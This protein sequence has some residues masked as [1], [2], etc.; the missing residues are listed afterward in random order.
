MSTR[1]NTGS[2][3]TLLQGQTVN[4]IASSSLSVSVTGSWLLILNSSH[5][6]FTVSF[7]GQA[8]VPC[9]AGLQIPSDNEFANIIFTDL[10]GGGVA[11]TYLVSA[12]PVAFYPPQTS[13]ITKDA[14][15]YTKASSGQP[16]AGGASLNYTGLDGTKV[17]KQIVVTNL[18]A[19]NP[20]Y[21]YDG[22]PGPGAVVYPQ[23]SWTIATGGIVKVTN[24][25]GA[26]VNVFVLETFYS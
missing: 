24:P 25:N 16:L 23:R 11:V 12:K 22:A 18:D 3:G 21:I 17:R 14:P 9:A 13:V 10:S 4:V 20:I 2:V 6:N 8:P 19:A 15:T 26:G 7:D 1:A 5:N